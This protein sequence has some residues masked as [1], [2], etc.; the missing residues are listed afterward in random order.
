MTLVS[1]HCTFVNSWTSE[2]IMPYNYHMNLTRVPAK[3]G[4][5]IN[6]GWL[7]DIERG[8]KRR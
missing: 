1:E 5:L 2:E 6:I 8:R 7:F 3:E 4:E